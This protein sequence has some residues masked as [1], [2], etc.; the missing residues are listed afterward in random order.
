V[1]DPNDL[2]SR[3]A[4]DACFAYARARLES[5][6]PEIGRTSSAEPLAELL[7][8]AI[9]RD[10]LGVDA[11]MQLV[12]DVVSHNSVALDSHRFIALIPA[13]P[14]LAAKAFDAV[15]AAMTYSPETWL[16]GAGP[17]AAENEAL[18]VLADAAGLPA[19]AGGCFVSGGSAGNLAA[20]AVARDQGRGVGSTIL[21]SAAA[22]A[23][24]ERAA[25][26][27][28][29][30]VV[31]VA[32]DRHGRMRGAE[33]AR[34]LDE[35]GDVSAVVV[36]A[37][38]TNAGVIDELDA[39]AT[40]CREHDVW[41]HVDAA[42]GG[43]ALLAPSV[44]ERFRGIERADSIVIDPHKWLFCTL[45]CGALLYRDPSRAVAT[46][47][48]EASYLELLH[49]DGGW[50]PSDYAF[51]LTRRARGLPFWFSMV[52]YGLDA[53]RDAIERVLQLT[54]DAAALIH[55]T[56]NVQLLNDPELSVLLFA[57][58]EW[59]EV[60]YLD[61]ARALFDQGIAFV[62]P[63]R[64]QGEV[65]GRAVFLHPDTPL[66]LFRTVLHAMR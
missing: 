24:V 13:A 54:R 58:D 3:D 53:Y 28:G 37:G 4:I 2:V 62:V 65:V 18:R 64:W 31:E 32:A 16:E 41:M 36:S 1:H 47:R 42:Y 61:W 25:H 27:L 29:L 40:A 12:C 11:A 48:Q 55:A 45:D 46:F 51:H 26:L 60:D 19:A 57:R 15:V 7:R 14:T 59:S 9:T 66:D 44:R 10:G 50:N 39:I 38:T 5:R 23:S 33:V 22:H 6:D 56:P 43:G 63:S 35:H 20:L 8:G 52:V 21:V 17:V 49:A 30:R 34:T